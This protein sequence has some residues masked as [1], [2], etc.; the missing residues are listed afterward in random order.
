VGGFDV[1]DRDHD[2]SGHDLAPAHHGRNGRHDVEARR[3]SVDSARITSE[4]FAIAVPPEEAERRCRRA[5]VEAWVGRETATFRLPPSRLALDPTD[6]V[7]LLHDGR[8]LQLRIAQTTDT[9]ARSLDCVRQDRSAYDLP[10]GAPRPAS[11]A[12]PVV[13]GVPDAVFLDL[14]QLREDVPAHRPFLAATAQPWPGQLAVFRSPALD[15]FAFL[16]AV[17]GQAIM[18]T[19]ATVL[20]P[21]PVSIFDLGNSMLIDVATGTLASVTDLDLFGGANAFGVETSPGVW[22]ILQAAKVEL[23]SAGRYKLSRLLRGQR[24]TE[25]AMGNPTPIGARIMA[26]DDR[27]VPLSISESEIGI[28]WN[29][30]IGPSSR[31]LT[32][33][34][35]LAAAFT[36]TGRGLLPFAP[37]N[38]EQPWRTG[39]APGDL[40]IRWVRRSRDLSADSWEIGEPPLAETTEA[41]EVDIYNGVALKRTLTTGTPSALYTATQQ[42]ADFGA[43]LTAGQS[44]TVR[45]YQLSARLGRGAPAIITLF[46]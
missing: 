35:Y 15:G 36:P 25:A 28:P 8:T 5:L 29:W 38:V 39:R 19:L 40:T 7:G 24:G 27:T 13:F 21:G 30:R 3:S 42:T 26:L 31:S 46:T 44:F 41:Y 4:A 43:A 18:G 2:I 1:G 14:P 16:T 11:I 9:D 32:D 33:P 6:V 37:V 45:I 12:R 22:E 17:D 34:T 10:P 23:V 20:Y